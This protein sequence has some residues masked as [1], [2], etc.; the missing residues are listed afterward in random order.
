[1]E[2]TQPTIEVSPTPTEYEACDQCGAALD[3]AQR[4]CVMCGHHRRH[5]RD[6]AARYLARSTARSRAGAAPQTGP[7]R[8]APTLATALI[9]AV[10]PLAIGLGVLVGRASNNGDGKLIAALRNQQPE[11]ITTPGGAGVGAASST[12]GGA[13]SSTGAGA[14]SSASASS[15]T[16]TFP[17][18]TGY[19]VELETLPARGTTA[20]SVTSA[21]ATARRKGASGV[22]LI[23]PSDFRVTPAPPAG[24]YVVYAGAFSQ[25]VAAAKALA[26][27]RKRF[28][29][30]IVIHVAPASNGQ[31]KVLARSR[32][33]TAHQV[34]GYHA[35]R[36]QL[37]QGGQI[38][39]KIQ[40]KVGNNFVQSQRGLP[41]QI[42]VP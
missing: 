20:A 8:R 34:S 36:A 21:E 31:G 29:K 11:V 32:F 15:L 27:L 26:T 22:G 16:S 38:V 41:D 1:M 17:L 13:A 9:I 18:Q 6:P 37:A 25:Q 4:Y 35:T 3:H 39:Q 19:A 23:L 2:D 42:S 5:V 7:R 10:I 33:G 40:K 28:P 30:A 24:A 12:G 14:A